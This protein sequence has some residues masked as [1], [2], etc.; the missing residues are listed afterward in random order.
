M[1]VR[2]TREQ[3]EQAQVRREI[4]SYAWSG[5]EIKANKIESHPRASEGHR[6][7]VSEAGFRTDMKRTLLAFAACVLVLVVVMIVRR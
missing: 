5:S 2:R 7:P 4:S 1:G 3:K 6:S